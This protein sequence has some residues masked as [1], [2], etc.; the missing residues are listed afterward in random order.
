MEETIEAKEEMQ[1]AMLSRETILFVAL[2]LA[3]VWGGGYL[4][5]Q[6]IGEDAT[7]FFF[8]FSTLVLPLVFIKL[9]GESLRDI[10]VHR[11]LGDKRLYALLLLAYLLIIG[12]LTMVTNSLMSDAT[13]DA[14]LLL[15]VLLVL[16]L[17]LLITLV[18]S[19]MEEL[20]WAGWLYGKIGAQYLVKVSAISVIWFVWHLPFYLW[21]DQF[22]D[23]VP[24]RLE[25]L[26]ILLLYFFAF[27]FVYSWFREHS[28]NALWATAAHAVANAAAFISV[29]A[30]DVPPKDEAHFLLL[31]L[32]LANTAVAA[33]LHQWR[34]VH[35]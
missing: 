27:R 26:A 1:A 3:W 32:A 13:I 5:H 25:L 6:T 20:T 10:A 21:T 19:F 31:V 28:G 35:R 15:Q 23:L 9:K 2:L 34:P 18:Q 4:L 22:V 33:A 11:D 30:I 12:V 8:L 29:I 24:L 17:I 7:A 16:P 14:A